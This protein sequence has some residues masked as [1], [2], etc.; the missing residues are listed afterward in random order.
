M[1]EYAN[2]HYRQMGMKFHPGA[3][4]PHLHAEMY[5][6]FH[7]LSLNQHPAEKIDEIGVSK[8]ICPLCLAVLDSLGIKYNPRWTSSRN[9]KNWVDPWDIVAGSCKI[10]RWDDNYDKYDK[11]K[12]GKGGHGLGGAVS[13]TAF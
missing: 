3:S 5:A 10:E 4:V 13:S 6:V 11:D 7:Y 2:T 8:Q 12:G 9:S 1:E